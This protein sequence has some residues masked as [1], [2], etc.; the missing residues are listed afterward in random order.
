MNTLSSW[1]GR[2]TP[3][4]VAL[5]LALALIAAGCGRGGSGAGDAAPQRVGPY[6]VSVTTQPDPPRV[7]DD[8]LRIDVRDADGKPVRGA[9][10]SVLVS[11]PAMGAMPY[12]ESRGKVK[13][14]GP[15]VYRAGYGLAMNGEWDVTIRIAAAGGERVE[16]AYRLSTQLKGLAPAG[17]TPPAGAAM[18]AMPG[19]S[20]GG[21]APPSGAAPDGATGAVTMD[22]ARRQALGIRTAKVELRDLDATVRAVGRIGYDESHAAE[23]TLK[24]AGFVREIFADFTGR[25]VRKGDALFTAYSPEVWSAQQEFLEALYHGEADTA[26]AGGVTRLSALAEAARQRLRLWDV[27]EGAVDELART[28]RAREALPVPATASGVVTEKNVVRGSAFSAGQVLFKIAPLDPVWVIASVYQM[29]LPLV[30]VGMPARLLDPYLD[31][32]SRAGRVSFVSPA[33]ERDTRTVQVRIEVPNAN[34]ALKPGMFVDVELQAPLG[35]RLAVPE[36]AVLP[37]GE[38]HVVFV[39]L[40]DGRLAPRQVRLGRRAGQWYEVLEGLAA[41]DM[42][43]SSGNFLVAADSKLRSAAQKW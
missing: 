15:G 29:D 22:G 11:M 37:T 9:E 36:S 18:G 28:R 33:L 16:A 40:G 35:R 5:G 25:P 24:Y 43:V 42:V 4:A 23:V 32:G 31:A 19:M 21:A 3:A 1:R 26:A 38:R 34:G 6:R 14:A 8:A 10:V 2:W 27:P 17:S 12:M 41:G 20:H 7:G 30:K 13:E 39:D